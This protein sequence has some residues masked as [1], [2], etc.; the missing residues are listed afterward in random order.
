MEV[1]EN[2]KWQ[3]GNWWEGYLK[4]GLRNKKSKSKIG[5]RK[6]IIHLRVNVNEREKHTV[7]STK[8]RAVVR[9]I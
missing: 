1:I 5:G 7:E 6:K 8:V 2:L 3:T 9:K 4:Q